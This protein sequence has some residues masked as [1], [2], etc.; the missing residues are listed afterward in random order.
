[1]K[2][3]AVILCMK[4]ESN[5]YVKAVKE[6]LV[7]MIPVTM[8]GSFSLLFRQLPI[9]AYQEFIT[10]FGNGIF[11]SCFDAIHAATFGVFS[12]YICLA[13]SYCLSKEIGAQDKIM[14]IPSV[15]ALCTFLEAV[16]FHEGKIDVTPLGASGMFLAIVCAL[17]SAHVYLEM[18][19]WFSKR[20]RLS[21]GTDMFLHSAV[22]AILPATFTVVF[23]Y[24]VQVLICRL[25]AVSDFWGLLRAFYDALSMTMTDNFRSSALFV[26]LNTFL[27]F[28]GVHGSDALEL[29]DQ[30]VFDPAA[31][32]NVAA[33]I[34]GQAPQHLYTRQFFDCFTL[35]GGTGN[36][37]SLLLAILLFSHERDDRYVAKV[38]ALPMLFN[39]N[40]IMTFGLPIV[41]N[42]IMFFPFILAPFASFLIS[43]AAMALK[44]VPY[45]TH[46]V[47]WT[48]PVIWSGY[49]V[50]GSI[51]GSILQLVNLAVGFLI[52]LPFVR[53]HDAY[54]AAEK[55]KELDAL[56]AIYR[57]AEEHSRPVQLTAINGNIGNMARNLMRDL[58]Q[59]VQDGK[60]TMFYQPQFNEESHMFGAEALVRWKHSELG[61]IYPPLLFELGREGGFL[62]K[63][64]H[65]IFLH[66]KEDI[67]KTSGIQFSI[68]ITADTVRNRQFID[69]LTDSFGTILQSGMTIYIEI[70]EQ[71]EFIT[72]EL[73]LE[74]L[75]LL[76]K[77]GFYLSIDDFSM[78]H[79]SLKYLQKGEF[80][81]VK[82]DGSLSKNLLQ[83]NK[84]AKI[85]DSIVYLSKISGFSVLAEYVE[86]E[87]QK[88]RLGELGC[89]IYQGYLYSP[90]VPFDRLC[91]LV[92]KEAA[93]A[94]DEKTKQR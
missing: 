78:G 36:T 84:T 29:V 51:R 58:R 64:E 30:A 8:I 59:D 48:V 74:N 6:G 23:F 92:K 42:P 5:A 67:S 39:V 43:T 47:A 68:N 11:Y 49:L 82:L 55:K 18:R 33:A 57:K 93:K 53:L 76:K 13:I 15:T 19:K 16:G 7:M 2:E 50:T 66:T 32:A 44:L 21:G 86:T 79:T 85:I 12:V 54:K 22:E 34:L 38:S 75:R 31:K 28:F 80:D 24:A 73:M 27:W 89:H 91:E 17:F 83:D 60:L 56:I 65:E 40:E 70:T 81:Q 1:M 41:Y 26:F 77:A 87:Q 3:K 72:D 9:T 10:G 71:S 20:I 63:L 4:L 14:I 94:A 25:F 88:Q 69:F 37:L 52:Y 45:T 35:I 46:T 90:A 62:T 61:Y